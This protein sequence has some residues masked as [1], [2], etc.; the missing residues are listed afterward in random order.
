MTDAK[1]KRAVAAMVAV[2]AAVAIFAIATQRQDQGAEEADRRW[3][4]EQWDVARYCLVGTPIGRG[5]SADR[6]AAQIEGQ[7]FAAL[8][9]MEDGAEAEA[10]WPLRCLGLLA[11]L[12]D[13]PTLPTDPETALGR[14]EVAVAGMLAAPVTV[15]AIP[16]RARALAEPVSQLDAIMPS[17]AEYDPARY[18]T[19]DPGAGRAAIVRSHDCPPVRVARRPLLR[20]SIGG[21]TL[22]DERTLGEVSERIVGEADDLRLSRSGP[23]VDEERPLSAAGLRLP[24]FADADHLVWLTAGDPPAVVSQ[25][26]ADGSRSAPVPLPVERAVGWAVRDGLWILRTGSGTVLVRADHPDAAVG[27]QP[28][29]PDQGVVT[30]TDRATLALAWYE[31]ERWVGVR[32]GERCAPL[33]PLGAGGDLQLALARGRLLALARGARSD[34]TLA[35]SLDPG[36]DDWSDPVPVPRGALSTA[37]DR[38]AVESCAGRWTSEDAATWSPSDR[39]RGS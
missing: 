20:A 14:V 37:G 39:D 4:G 30:A 36:G 9:A 11:Q 17:G 27:V 16:E 34:L 8:A 2:G 32:C 10:R 28:A 35:R 22:H 3:Y 21:E 25:D 29:P 38:F 19:V 7:A 18:P 13:P 15:A 12:R 1:T 33:P 5:D 23:G 31:G 6:I 26:L 24:R